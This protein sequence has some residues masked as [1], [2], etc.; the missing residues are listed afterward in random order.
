MGLNIAEHG[1]KSS[2]LDLAST[3]DN[4]TR[5]GDFSSDCRVPVEYGTE[6]GDLAELFNRM[7]D[8]IREA[9][10]ES[11]NQRKI[12]QQ[13]LM[14][15]ENQKKEVLKVQRE[16]E[17][18]KYESGLN[19]SDYISK[20]VVKVGS[21]TDGIEGIKQ[22]LG[23]TS[24]RTH[25]MTQN[26]ETMS[27]SLADML[28]SLSSVYKQLEQVR[29]VTSSTSLS[30]NQSRRSIH[31]LRTVTIDVENMVKHIND[32]ADRTG[33]LSI[34][35]SIEAARAGDKGSGFSVISREVRDLS[36][37][38]IK[39]ASEIKVKLTDM[40]TKVS[41][42]DSSMENIIGIMAEISRLNMDIVTIVENNQKFS[43]SV[44]SDSQRT[45]GMVRN[46]TSDIKT[47]VSQAEDL[48][49]TGA[50][51]QRELKSIQ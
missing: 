46:V 22:F 33:I 23:Q 5:S 24:D 3:M 39:V 25:L 29:T 9:L 43:E 51:V 21:V 20:T 14:E 16:L 12:A 18:E 42:V 38:T 40:E 50:Q 10:E 37:E 6:I 19:R 45:M 4:L 34:N 49:L 47:V 17:N 30:V 8:R 36:E 41:G 15:S 1:A 32:L 7:I 31:D 35:S 13:M 28:I 48:A 26:F 44:S 27:Q 2:I 11:R